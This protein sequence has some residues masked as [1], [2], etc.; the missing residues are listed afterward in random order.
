MLKHPFEVNL[1]ELDFEEVD[2]EMEV[3]EATQAV[4]A[5][6]E[7]TLENNDPEPE[8]APIDAAGGDDFCLHPGLHRLFFFSGG[9]R[10]T[11]CCQ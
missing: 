11:W 4:A 6:E 5:L 9:L 2:K 7:N 8:D 1:D 10:L 3:D